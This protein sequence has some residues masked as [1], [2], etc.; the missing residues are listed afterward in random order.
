MKTF[1]A[2]Y[3]GTPAAMSKWNELPEAVRAEPQE[4]GVPENPDNR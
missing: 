1:L 2:V 3:I 4:A